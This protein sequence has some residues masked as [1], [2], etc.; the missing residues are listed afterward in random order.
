[1]VAAQPAQIILFA[2]RLVQRGAKHQGEAVLV[3]RALH[4]GGELGEIGIADIRDHQPDRI[5]PAP[6]EAAGIG[7]G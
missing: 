3:G 1:M 2:R 6:A 4:R 5:G 7:F